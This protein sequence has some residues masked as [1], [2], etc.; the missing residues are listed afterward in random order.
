MA[1]RGARLRVGLH[2]AVAAILVNVPRLTLAFLEADGVEVGPG[3]RAGLLAVTGVAT[4]VVLTGGGAYLAHALSRGSRF[5][6]LLAATWG[7]V[8]A[9]AAVLV[10]PA[11]VAGLSGSELAAV[12]GS[13][14]LRWAWSGTAVLAVELVAAGSMLAHAAEQGELERAEH[15]EQELLELAR[16]RNRLEARL[17]ELASPGGPAP[18]P[19]RR[20]ALRAAAPPGEPVPCRN[21]CGFLGSSPM[22]ERG[23]LRSCPLRPERPGSDRVPSTGT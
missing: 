22:A 12:L 19:P 9:C 1:E 13:S 11:L 2:L 5:R 18:P 8:L 21:G 20:R 6:P 4:G 7:L 3:L 14:W 17:A 15:A 16:Q 23:H 10:T